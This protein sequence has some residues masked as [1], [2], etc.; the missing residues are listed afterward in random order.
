MDGFTHLHVHTEYSLLDGAAR[1]GDLLDAAK[2]F[3]M[4]SLAIT[5]HGT[6]YGVVD[7]YKAA[8][9]R[10]VKP[11]IGC[12]VYVAPGNEPGAR[13]ERKEIDGTKYF[14]LVLLAENNTGYKNLVKLASL[15]GTEGFYYRPRVDKEILRKYHDGLIALTAC[16]VGEIPRAILEDKDLARARELIAEYVDIFGRDNF[17]LEIQNHGLESEAKVRNA[18]KKLSAELNIPLVATNDSHYVR[19][20]DWEFHDLLLCIQTGKTLKSDKRLKFSSDD[21]YLKSAEEMRA[22]FADTPDACDNT[23]AV[24]DRCNVTLEFGKFQM[25]E[26]PLPAG[27]TDADYLRGLCNEKLPARYETVT[28]E[29][30]ARLDYELDVIH[31]MGYD[32]YFLIV[33]DFI[34]FARQNGIPV[35]PGRG[36]AAGSLVAYVL[37]ITELDPL[38]YNLLF[39]RFLN[40]ERVTL[41]DIDVDLCYIRREEVIEYVRQRYGAEKVAQIATFGTLAAKA[42]IRDVARVLDLSYA[43]SSRIVKLMPNTLNITLDD[44]LKTSKDFRNEYDTNADTRR[45]IDFARKLEGLPRN[46]SVHA[47]G[48]VISKEP[49]NE[50]VPLQLSS[51]TDDAASNKVTVTQYDKDKIEELGL[52]K[53]DFLGLRTLTIMAETFKNIKAS[54]GLTLTAE[55]IPLRDAKTA[56]MLTAGK[57]SGVFQMESPGMTTLVKELR[58]EGFEDLIPTVALYRPGPLGSGMVEDFIAGRH[59]RRTPTYLHP[60]LEP[61]LK[62]TFGVI[63]YQEQVMQIVRTLAGFTLGQ[64]DIL[65]RAMSKKKASILLEQKENFLRGCEVNGVEKP[66]AEKIFDLLS[67]FADYGFNKSH[68]AAY[69]LLAWQTAYLKAHYP[70]EYLAAMMSDTPD[71]DKVAGYI[72]QARRAGIKILAPDVNAGDAHFT[73][74]GGAIR[75]GLAAVKTVSENVANCIVT[76]RAVNGQFKSPLDL[77]GRLDVKTVPRRSLENLIKCGAFDSLEQRRAALLTS[78]DSIMAAGYKRIRETRGGLI[79]LF[80]DEDAHDTTIPLPDVDDSPQRI[81]SWEKE[82]L[83][84]Y[85][86]GHPLDAFRDKL[87]RLTSSN[88]VN[89]G[90]HL[91]RRV[92]VGGIITSAQR[93]TTKKGDTMAFLTLEDFD[94]TIDVTLFPNVFY[95]AVRVVQ[96]DEIVVVAGRVEQNGDKFQLVA[97]SVTAAEDYL[98]DFWLTIPAQIDN[99]A[100]FDKL[101]R[102]FAAHAGGSQVLINRDDNWRKLSIKISG[103][104]CDELKALLGEENVR[105]Y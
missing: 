96:P 76:E 63:L 12:E 98:P 66:L 19:R 75:F 45:V 104:A 59:G 94:G 85:L 23:L 4:T 48:V 1:I 31:G 11:I 88:D 34:N 26:F 61:I 37:G 87:S 79:N 67:K 32:G 42:S 100:T 6:M 70:A 8:Q 35:G 89:A 47:A 77:C 39:E 38:K 13:F 95:T 92:K 65:R 7:F 68:S 18:L 60:K 91:S 86:S 102:I 21:Y 90:K 57:T 16:V 101:K 2:N 20:A 78:I 97:N 52:L 24:A 14:H 25:P 105:L 36:S 82:T 84:F 10:G 15:A 33:W 27:T 46:L 73:V 54:R 30:K 69:G 22:L 93:V 72:E 40:P 9:K 53:M 83:G 49:L 103:G 56:A 71:I 64:A 62:E 55:Q 29:I 44:A 17:F 41:P 3:G 99:A 51:K 50:I 43:E 80:D 28:D 58:P 5:D 74:E 81:L